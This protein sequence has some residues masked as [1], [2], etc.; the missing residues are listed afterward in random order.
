ML[1][2]NEN[3]INRYADYFNQF[4]HKP[5]NFEILPMSFHSNCSLNWINYVLDFHQCHPLHFR[6]K[7]QIDVKSFAVAQM[8]SYWHAAVEF[9]AVV[10]IFVVL[11]VTT[12]N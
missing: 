8:D 1:I 3:G 2:L 11:A 6:W 12:Q 5:N 7:S 4:A 10:P 9:V